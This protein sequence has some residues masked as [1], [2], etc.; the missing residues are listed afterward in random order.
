MI[1]FSRPV[2]ERPPRAVMTA[3][4]KRADAKADPTAFVG[5]LRLARARLAGGRAGRPVEQFQRARREPSALHRQDAR[6]AATQP[7]QRPPR[8]LS[9]IAMASWAVADQLRLRPRRAVRLRR[10]P[11]PIERGASYRARRARSSATSR[12]STAPAPA[13]A[14][15]PAAASETRATGDEPEAFGRYHGVGKTPRRARGRAA[16]WGAWRWFGGP[17]PES[18]L[19]QRVLALA[20][21]AFGPPR[22]L[23]RRRWR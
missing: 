6:S 4:T 20:R 16:V 15:H 12:P 1:L 21:A 5:Y 14:R 11:R 13:T 17:P 9:V 3:L 2:T 18:G 23:R 10:T 8:G 7:R 19:G 22:T